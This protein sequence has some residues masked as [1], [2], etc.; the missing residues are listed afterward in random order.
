LSFR[1]VAGDKKAE[2][3]YHGFVAA[4][5]ASIRDTHWVDSNK[6]SGRGLFDLMLTPKDKQQ[7]HRALILEFKH[8]KKTETLDAMAEMALAQIENLGYDAVLNRHP[9]ITQVLKVGLAFSGKE[10]RSVYKEENLLTRQETAMN[11]TETYY[12]EEL[13]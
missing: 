3:F 11:W 13:E 12:K 6:E 7:H 4:L 2:V 9:H 5:V 1:D 8:A 10:V